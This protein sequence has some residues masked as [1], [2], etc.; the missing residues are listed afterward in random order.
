MVQLVKNLPAMWVREKE[1]EKA[2]Q[3][4]GKRCVPTWETGSLVLKF[5]ES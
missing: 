5:S 1:R 2:Q 4:T 3:R